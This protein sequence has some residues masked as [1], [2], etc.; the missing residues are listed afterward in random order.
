MTKTLQELESIVETKQFDELVEEVEN[1]CFDV[2]GQRYQFDAGDYARRELAKDVTSFA[3]AG[4]GYI[5]IGATTK[6]SSAHPGEEVTE[7]RPFPAGLIDADRHY[8]ILS[9][10]THPE[11]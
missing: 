3:N 10:W 7:L 9:E 6:K 11:P 8:K 5:F 1:E 4:G 2:K